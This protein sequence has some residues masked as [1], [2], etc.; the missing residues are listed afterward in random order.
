MMY[1]FEF[2]AAVNG[3]SIPI[4]EI[5]KGKIKGEAKII[6]L[7]DELEARAREEVSF[8][9]MKLDTRGFQ[10]NREELTEDMS[11]GQL[12]ENSL[13]IENIFAL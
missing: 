11:D 5:Y 13:R 8:D 10:F 12:I 3:D 1:A 4:P 6:V 2:K 7:A 9:A